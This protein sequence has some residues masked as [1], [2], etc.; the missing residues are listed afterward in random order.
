MWPPNADGR[1][2]EPFVGSGVVALNLSAER[3]ILADTNKH[4]IKLYQDI[5]KGE[6]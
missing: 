2:I 5:Q 3:A 6:L 4:I 1:W